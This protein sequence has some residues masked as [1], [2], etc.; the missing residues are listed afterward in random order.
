MFSFFNKFML[1][2]LFIR[3]FFILVL[4]LSTGFAMKEITEEGLGNSNAN[5]KNIEYSQL[6]QQNQIQLYLPDRA[7]GESCHLCIACSGSQNER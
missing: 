4:P 5:I 1:R 7:W 6:N 2:S 3:S